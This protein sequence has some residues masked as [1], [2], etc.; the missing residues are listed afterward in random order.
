MWICALA[1]LEWTTSGVAA[2][3]VRCG[4]ISRRDEVI[5]CALRCL[6]G[7]FEATFKDANRDAQS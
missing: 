5:C 7:P 1:V 2:G 6:T 3:G 4:E